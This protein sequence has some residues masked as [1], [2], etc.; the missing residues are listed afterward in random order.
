M[1][2][3]QVQVQGAADVTQGGRTLVDRVLDINTTFKRLNIH[4]GITPGGIIIP[5]YKDVQNSSF[6]YVTATGIDAIVLNLPFPITVYQAGQSFKFKAAGTTTGPSTI[7]IDGLGALSLKKKDVNTGTLASL[8]AGDVIIG[9]VYTAHI[10]DA[11]N[12]LLESVDSGGITSVS[13]GDLN[14]STG[15]V[16]FTAVDGDASGNRPR[17]YI[18]IGSWLDSSSYVSRATCIG[19]KGDVS[20]GT[21]YDNFMNQTAADSSAVSLPGGQYG[22]YPQSRKT[23]GAGSPETPSLQQRYVTASPPFD[24][25]DGEMAGFVFVLLDSAGSV[26]SHYAADVPP[27]GYNGKTDI[28]A[29]RVCK[30]TGRK[31]REV[32]ETLS[33]DEVIAGKKPSFIQQEITHEI[34]NRDMGDIPH[35]FG[36][37][38]PGHTVVLLDTQSDTLR[39]LVDFQNAGGGDDVTD[40]IL[41][42]HLK[43]DNDAL[44]LISPNGVMTC[45]FRKN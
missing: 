16:S 2:T 1:P 32:L 26:V 17:Y 34:K 21:T 5:N 23:G 11:S 6:S 8:A 19:A 28:R 20:L 44:D 41:S 36:V 38:P 40:F 42:K 7:N 27:W 4:D 31:Y 33:L 18:S 24:L 15:T 43:I 35:P 3:T 12:A 10:L 37:V 22:M 9:G 14:T 29:C 39:N 45:A 13:Q 30:I 25:G